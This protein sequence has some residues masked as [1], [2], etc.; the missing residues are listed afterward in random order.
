MFKLGSGHTQVQTATTS[1]KTDDTAKSSPQKTPQQKTAPTAMP[2]SG[3]QIGSF[4]KARHKLA[5]HL[6]GGHKASAGTPRTAS[7]EAFA[8]LGFEGAPTSP[9]ASLAR[10]SSTA[11]THSHASGT[12][13]GVTK[14]PVKIL[15][16]D[17]TGEAIG[18]KSSKETGEDAGKDSAAK[19]TKSDDVVVPDV[20]P[21]QRDAQY[22]ATASLNQKFESHLQGL[23]LEVVHNSGRSNNCAI[24]SL[25]DIAAPKL[26]QG[27]RHQA[28]RE[29]RAAFDSKRPDEA[30]KMLLLDMGNGGH[31]RDLVSLVNKKYGVDLQVGV[32]QAGIDD[33]HPVTQIATLR[34]D[35]AAAKPPT[36]RGVVWDQ[37]GHF[38]SVR[39]AAPKAPS[40]ETAAPKTSAVETKTATGTRASTQPPASPPPTNH[41]TAGTATPSAEKTGS[42]PFAKLAS[43]GK[44]RPGASTKPAAKATES[45]Q[46]AE[47][48]FKTDTKDWAK[49][50][51][52][53]VK[54]A[55]KLKDPADP[56][57]VVPP[58]KRDI[59]QAYDR[60]KP[61]FTAIEAVGIRP[62]GNLFNAT[63]A[64]IHGEANAALLGTGAGVGGI[65]DAMLGAMNGHALAASVQKGKRYEK[66]LDSM[67]AKDV[68][69]FQK[70]PQLDTLILTKDKK[71]KFVYD[72]DKVAKLAASDKPEHKEAAAHAKNVFL[73][74][75]IKDE[76]AGKRRNRATYELTRNTVGFASAGAV[77]GG[78]LGIAAAPGA[79]AAI[80]AKSAGLSLG[81]A[82]ALDLAKGVRGLK[83]RMRDDKERD[84]N[85]RFLTKRM[86]M[87]DVAYS[88][89]TPQEA[90]DGA[91]AALKANA[92]SEADEVLFRSLLTGK[93]IDETKS[94]EAKK[95]RADIA[96]KHA[97]EVV[98]YHV[99]EFAT[100]KEGNLEAFHRNLTE[101]GLSQRDKTKR[102]ASSVKED[103]SLR[104]AYDLMRDVGMRRSE[105]NV[106]IHALIRRKI[107]TEI[108]QDPNRT[109]AATVAAQK[110]DG[111]PEAGDIRDMRAVLRR[112]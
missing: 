58:R 105:A 9:R 28:A 61:G 52:K 80:G 44:W 2:A 12:S 91:Q 7:S 14:P 42:A 4:A 62:F 89:S 71:G 17:E 82:N 57:F 96:A 20:T 8:K 93:H 38:E 79:A 70:D 11:S 49:D 1:V 104:S 16:D 3:L 66:Q 30:G 43:I 29:I 33:Q 37:H 47:F 40:T 35:D 46:L 26:D 64:G 76:V 55:S 19:T 111:K 88:S 23:G 24:Y 100:E 50:T 45:Y 94:T 53:A 54:D 112:H 106:A 99:N 51:D 36:H 90:I 56:K 60:S 98:D 67:L 32:V 34:A 18:K 102:L 65:H 48:D 73:T 6:P 108:A 27:E 72:M 68:E 13:L 74:A 86:D 97:Y 101:P 83:Q 103:P 39:A 31:G 69:R 15:V 92:K 107:D 5:S 81:F 110:Y 75:Y 109:G 21:E 84:I 77:L 85:D 95:G 59:G 22:R 10:T 63:A 78:T 41:K 87:K 25:L